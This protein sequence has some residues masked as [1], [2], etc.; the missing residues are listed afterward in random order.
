MAASLASGIF[1]NVTYFFILFHFIGRVVSLTTPLDVTSN[2]YSCYAAKRVNFV[3]LC[4]Q[5]TC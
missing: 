4:S 2:F 3:Q 1:W 5:H